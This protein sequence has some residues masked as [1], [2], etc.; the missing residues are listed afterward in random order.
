MG[1]IQLDSPPP[2]GADPNISLDGQSGIIGRA[3]RLVQVEERFGGF[4]RN[5][6]GGTWVVKSLSDALRLHHETQKAVRF[7]TLDGEIV[8]ADGSVFI[9]PKASQLGLVS[10]RSELRALHRE[11]QRIEIEI[12]TLEDEIK[13]LK[14][15]T[16]ESEQEVA[17]LIDQNTKLSSQL[18]EQSAQATATEKE[19]SQAQ[20]QLEQCQAS[21]E[22]SSGRLAALETKLV[23]ER[24]K[25]A[26]NELLVSQLTQAL[27]SGQSRSDQLQRQRASAEKETTLAKVSLA[28]HEQQLETLQLQFKQYEDDYRE[29][30][31]SLEQLQSQLAS[32]KQ[33]RETATNEI[34]SGQRQLAEQVQARDEL[35]ER[36]TQLT[37]QR[38][39]VDA[40][41][42]KQA[43]ELNGLRDQF[44]NAQ[45]QLHQAQMRIE[46]LGL[47]RTQLSER[48]R[49]DYDIDISKIEEVPLTEEEVEQRDKIDEEI[50]SLRKKNRQ[51]RRCERRSPV[52]IGGIG[53]PLSENG[54]TV[55]GFDPGQRDARK[56]HRPNQRR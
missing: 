48:L 14:T 37:Q 40:D 15:H 5:L 1:L 36:L 8:E 28:K 42:R 55:P 26:T 35:N 56:N 31:Q 19:L 53:S 30:Q 22:D 12:S 47:Q 16:S 20:S 52:R 50:T 45:D 41:R 23:G 18:S 46:Q 33:A 24:E 44:R 27:D 4:V 39:E 7:V 54:R 25:L 49:D 2:P 9:G 6:L 32:D 13:H 17:Q 51:H 29:H 34:E 43:I 38:A 3:D 21:F 11:L 10:R